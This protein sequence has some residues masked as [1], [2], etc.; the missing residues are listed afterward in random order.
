MDS[1]AFIV[2]S[3]WIAIALISCVF[4]EVGGINWGT[5]IAVALFV[6]L[7]FIVTFGVSFGLEGMR[8]YGPPSTTQLELSKNLNEMKTAISDLTK[9]VDAIQKEIDE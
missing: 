5:D 7:A 3:C 1:R 6:L 8:R 4:I 9:K 2:A